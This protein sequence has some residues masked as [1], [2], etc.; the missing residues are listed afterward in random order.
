MLDFLNAIDN[1]VK[2]IADIEEGHISSA[3]CI[4]ANIS[5]KTGRQLIYDPKKR[6]VVGDPEASKLLQRVY[7]NP[8]VHPDPD[9]I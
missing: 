7:R 8:W 9:N 6:I 1:N 4:L 5:M 2:P 3:S